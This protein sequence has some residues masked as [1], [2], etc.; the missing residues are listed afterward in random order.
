MFIDT[1]KKILLAITFLLILTILFIACRNEQNQESEK[2]E[3]LTFT[4]WENICYDRAAS[5][6]LI[7][8]FVDSTA[9]FQFVEFGKKIETGVP[10][11]VPGAGLGRQ[12][13]FSCFETI[14]KNYNIDDPAIIK[15]S[16][17]VHDI[18]VNIW[19]NKIYLMSDSLDKSFKAKRDEIDDEYILLDKL[20]TDFN[21]LYNQI[22]SGKL[23]VE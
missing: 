4:T 22:Q 7:R 18:D 15:M 13:N 16:G 11:D 10:F 1:F 23:E 5:I 14:I 20:A 8:N 6:W 21:L 3:G 9:K 12:K 2:G 19:G 17:I